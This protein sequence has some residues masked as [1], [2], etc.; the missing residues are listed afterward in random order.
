MRREAVRALTARQ[1]DHQATAD[2]LRRCVEHDAS[3]EVRGAALRWL[4]AGWRTAEATAGLLRAVATEPEELGEVR[5]V[6][7]TELAAGWPDEQTR[8]WL[9]DR[10]ADG[11]A[12]VQ[13]AA[14]QAL[15][16]G[17]RDD[18]TR[19]WLCDQ[20]ANTGQSR[21]RVAA[22]RGLAAGWPDGP[23]TVALLRT[24]A[25][26]ASERDPAV[27]QV[28]VEALAAGRGEDEQTA[29]WLRELVA[30][31]PD[32]DVRCVI[33]QALATYWRDEA[34]AELL[35]QLA[36]DRDWYVRAIAI[37]AVAD[38]R[39]D[40]CRAADWLPGWLRG[41]AARHANKTPYVRQVALNAAAAGWPTDPY[42]PQWLRD[43]AADPAEDLAVR[44]AALM[45]LAAR[46]PDQATLELLRRVGEGNARTGAMRRVAVRLVATGW[47][48]DP[49]TRPWLCERATRDD[50]P[51]VR[52][53][54]LQL[55]AAD[56][57]WHQDPDILALLGARAEA[58]PAPQVRRAAALTL[59]A[60]WS[61][62]QLAGA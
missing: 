33:A 58:D 44:G 18:H 26:A 46:W 30:A 39:A 2:L 3:P 57:E 19:R 25:Q 31:E 12:R 22:V 7:V 13:A 16:T 23:D 20:V 56:A 17:W 55:L 37:R 5:A 4:A 1:P 11:D 35:R 54:A 9:L 6:A 32:D 45:A 42:L 14:A 61:A 21:L 34:T 29:R 15:A 43:R 40:E 8:D 48:D 27:R 24:R 52:L 53:A 36:G 47:R 38:I 50:S 10:A 62:H 59:A 28:A 41:Q 51:T 49:P 60:S